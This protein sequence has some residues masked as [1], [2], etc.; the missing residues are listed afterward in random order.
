LV[1]PFGLS[2]TPATFQDMMNHIFRDMLDQ[3]VIA[4]IDDVLI[5]VETEEK[6]HKLI[7][8]VLKRLQENGLVISPEKCVWG[9]N[10]VE[11]LGYIISEEGIEMAKDKVETDLVWEL[12]KSLKEMQAFLGFANFYR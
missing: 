5:Y 4:Y 3:G 10:K 1:I 7:R 12:P 8:E 6:H 9:R 2:N 11:F